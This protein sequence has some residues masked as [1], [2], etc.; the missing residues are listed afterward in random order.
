[1]N[2]ITVFITL[3][4]YTVKFIVSFNT[5]NMTLSYFLKERE[6]LPDL[7][8]SEDHALSIDFDYE[9]V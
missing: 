6:N 2:S 8:Q 4:K 7:T 9:H 3:P 5:Y 1:M